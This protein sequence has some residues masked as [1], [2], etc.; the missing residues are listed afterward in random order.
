M[1][2]G[3]IQT[4]RSSAKTALE[5]RKMPKHSIMLQLQQAAEL[6]QKTLRFQTISFYIFGV[7]LALNEVVRLTGWKI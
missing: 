3:N 1:S 6:F 4:V 2:E 7:N 5:I